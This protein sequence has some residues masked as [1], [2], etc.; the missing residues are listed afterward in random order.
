MIVIG[1]A[2]AIPTTIPIIAPI[3]IFIL[4]DILKYIEAAP[5]TTQL[6]G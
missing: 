5:R 2:T 3:I 4:I 6:G 1:T